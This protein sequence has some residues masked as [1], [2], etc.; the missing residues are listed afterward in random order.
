MVVDDPVSSVNTSNFD[1]NLFG[2]KSQQLEKATGFD[3]KTKNTKNNKKASDY[4]FRSHRSPTLVTN[5]LQK[6]CDHFLNV[7]WHPLL[8]VQQLKVLEELPLS[9]H[10]QH[11][12]HPL[13]LVVLVL[14][15]TTKIIIQQ[16]LHQED[17]CRCP[18]S[19]Q[20]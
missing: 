12:L 4:S 1:T 20:K 6:P 7:L 16:R 13:H 17:P 15:T 9:Y 5:I 2:W 10:Y 14:T 8:L 3:C 18:L 19:Y 11:P